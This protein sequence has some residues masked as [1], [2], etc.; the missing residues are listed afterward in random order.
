MSVFKNQSKDFLAKLLIFSLLIFS[1][2]TGWPVIWENFPFP[3]KVQVAQAVDTVIFLTI[4]DS[5]PW[6][7]PTDWSDVNT[8]VAIG[9]G[10]GGGSTANGGGG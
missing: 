10:G 5:S 4:A 8:I 3:P 2:Y 9:G 1:F 7:V 6:T